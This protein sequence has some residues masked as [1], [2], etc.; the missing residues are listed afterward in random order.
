MS[1]QS[2]TVGKVFLVGAG[3][4]DPGLITLRGIECLQHRLL[5][6]PDPELVELKGRL[7]A[8]RAVGI[9]ESMPVLLQES[10]LK[11]A[12]FGMSFIF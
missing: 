8:L 12:E 3:P 9:K 7:L 1:Q 2:Q 5:V 4:G 11:P 10:A 6:E